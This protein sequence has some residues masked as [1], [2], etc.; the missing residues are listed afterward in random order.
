MNQ[1]SQQPEQT[2]L[3]QSDMDGFVDQQHQQQAINHHLNP[4][5]SD[6]NNIKN[7]GNQEPLNDVEFESG[8][9]EGNN[10]LD[11]GFVQGSSS[12]QEGNYEDE[13]IQGVTNDGG[14]YGEGVEQDDEGGDGEDDEGESV[15]M[16]DGV[17]MRMI[18][19]EGEENQY[20]MD[21][22]GRIYDMQ[23]NFIGTAN[24][25]GLEEMG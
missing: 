5:Y 14:Q 12:L 22:Q 16:I 18:Q 6:H 8:A 25:Q 10:H 13:G 21:P 20:L 24:T 17:V 1:L 19:I 4:Q 9:E 2:N 15:Y 11:G 3:H 7:G 23:A